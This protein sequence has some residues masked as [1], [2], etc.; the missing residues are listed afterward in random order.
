MLSD[1]INSTYNC[2]DTL[3]TSCE[4]HRIH[5]SL[6][7]IYCIESNSL[8]QIDPGTNNNLTTHRPAVLL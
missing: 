1:I 5:P 3:S 7:T 6:G 2:W 8:L 4:F